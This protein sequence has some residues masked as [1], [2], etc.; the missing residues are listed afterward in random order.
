M[1][2]SFLR[3]IK[4]T[5][6]GIGGLGASVGKTGELMSQP[7]IKIC[8]MKVFAYIEPT[9]IAIEFKVFDYIY[10]AD[11]QSIK[12]CNSHRNADSCGF[13]FQ[14]VFKDEVSSSVK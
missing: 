10:I 5:S 12:S 14:L 7:M 4:K 1:V 8:F 2:L 3:K 13:F 6:G 9:L 11:S